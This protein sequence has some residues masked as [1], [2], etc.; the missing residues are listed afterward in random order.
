[1][2]LKLISFKYNQ[3]DGFFIITLLFKEDTLIHVYAYARTW[4]ESYVC[5]HTEPFDWYIDVILD[6]LQKTLNSVDG[7]KV[8]VEVIGE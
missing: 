4:F 5:A 1:M 8:E 2:A 7:E 3:P 6:Y